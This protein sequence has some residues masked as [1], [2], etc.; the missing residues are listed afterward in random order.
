MKYPESRLSEEEQIIFDVHHHPVVLLKISLV[1]SLYL[2]A[3]VF[4]LVTYSFFRTRW[5]LMAGILV[6][7][8]LA[9]LLLVRLAKWSRAGLVLTNRRLIYT[10]GVL[11]RRTYEIPLVKV[12]DVSS[13]KSVLG[14]LV[15]CGDLVVL[16]SGE[17]GKVPFYFLRKTEALKRSIMEQVQELLAWRG[18]Q[19]EDVARQVAREMARNQPTQEMQAIPPERAPIYSEIVDQ[20][21]RLDLLR[22]RNSITEEEFREAKRSLLSR[23]D[24]E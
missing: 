19:S 15:G 22:E 5:I 3:W 10:S 6:F 18:P 9:V 23:L 7:V 17:G 11:S 16:T 14:R 20:I 4:L 2:A 1:L 12:N 8:F 13:L 21:E 24:E